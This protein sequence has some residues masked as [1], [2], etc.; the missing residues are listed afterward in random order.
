[1]ARG[2][3]QK[4]KDLCFLLFTLALASML[5]GCFG[6]LFPGH[7][8]PQYYQVD[9]PFVPSKCGVRF[10]GTVRIWPFSSSA[11]YN[12]RRMVA[13]SP[14][15]R[16]RFSSHYKWISPAGDMVANDLTRD[17]S[18]GKIFD[19]VVP[20]GTPVPAAY[21]I[22]GQI[23]R[24]ALEENGTSLHALLNV[25]IDFWREKP[26]TVLFR[27][28]FHYKSPPLASAGPGEF[29]S[30]MSSL[31][32]QL[33]TDLRNDLCAVTPGSSHPAGY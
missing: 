6:S 2:G 33:S 14:S 28:H 10:P 21:G 32:S 30:A 26:R 12:G 7:A 25:E 4:V 3:R 16:V 11:P 31:V 27:K 29:A 15:L 22:S 19:S 5:S 23:Y 18:F 1:M 8:A 24:F 20:A 17:L 9:Y 13:I